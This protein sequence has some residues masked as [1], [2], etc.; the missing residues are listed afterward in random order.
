MIAYLIVDEN[1]VGISHGDVDDALWPAFKANL[2]H[3][4]RIVRISH[5]LR[6][7][8]SRE[9]AYYWKVDV[10]ETLPDHEAQDLHIVKKKP[11]ALT[12][13]KFA[14]FAN[15]RPGADVHDSVKIEWSAPEPVK[16]Y[17]NGQAGEHRGSF[18]AVAAAPGDYH[19]QVDPADPNYYTVHRAEPHSAAGAGS[20][21]AAA[22]VLNAVL[23]E[24]ERP[25][26]EEE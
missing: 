17:Y 12:A 10:D 21:P 8:M 23:Q 13:S 5:E 18:L 7:L 16:M 6:M 11:L 20:H 26:W 9:Y 25:A 2:P 22:I 24:G 15:Y 3:G 19:V 14:M 4:D 1:G